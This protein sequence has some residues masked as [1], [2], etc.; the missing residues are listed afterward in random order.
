MPEASPLLYKPR[1]E[2]F[3]E[4]LGYGLYEREEALRLCVLAALARESLFLFGPPG[5]AKSLIARRLKEIFPKRA[6]A[7]EYL[8]HRFSTPDEIFGPISIK[9]LRHNDELVRKTERYL[10]GATVVFLDEI[11]KAGPSIQNTLLT[12]INERIFRNA[13]NDKTVPLRALIAASNELPA[14]GEGL[15]A[16]WDRFVL[17]VVVDNVKK[18]TSRHEIVRGTRDPQDFTFDGERLTEAD[19]TSIEAS[20]KRV[21]I[22]LVVLR[23]LDSVVSRIE[24]YNKEIEHEKRLENAAQSGVHITPDSEEMSGLLTVSDRRWFKIGRLLRASALLHDRNDVHLAD[25][26]LLRYCLWNDPSQIPEIDAILQLSV[27]A[28]LETTQVVEPRQND[29]NGLKR[30]F[31]RV[32][33]QSTPL[34]PFNK[35]YRLDLSKGA[36]LLSRGDHTYGRIAKETYKSL[37][38]QSSSGKFTTITLAADDKRMSTVTVHARLDQSDALILKSSGKKELQAFSETRFT[39]MRAPADGHADQEDDGTKQWL[40]QVHALQEKLR[41]LRQA[42]ADE[43]T[44]FL[45]ACQSHLFVEIGTQVQEALKAPLTRI[46]QDYARLLEDIGQFLDTHVR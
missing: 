37:R 27:A 26:F 11:W 35:D 23:M 17:R 21:A 7:F 2:G 20:I 29:W 31:E 45:A 8:M 41:T 46:D 12:V 1:V 42:L 25:T 34:Q 10:P 32:S 9:S 40:V 4:A 44:A 5:V 38:R 22:P 6:R 18:A 16:L 13:G 14:S 15:E 30:D 24:K 28:A 39:L 33:A 43:Q 3:I 19:L 36:G